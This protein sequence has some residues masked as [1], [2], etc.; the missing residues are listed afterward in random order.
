MRSVR[1]LIRPAPASPPV[2]CRCASTTGRR[3][4][5]RTP[6]TASATDTMAATTAAIPAILGKTAY[7]GGLSI[8]A[9]DARCSHQQCDGDR[10]D[11]R[12][13]EFHP[14][15]ALIATA[16]AGHCRP[17]SVL[18]ESKLAR[19]AREAAP[20]AARYFRCRRK[21]GRPRLCLTTVESDP[22]RKSIDR[23]VGSE[24]WSADYRAA[25]SFRAPRTRGMNSLPPPCPA[26]SRMCS[27]LCETPWR[28]YGI[29][30]EILIGL[31]TPCRSLSS[32]R[33]PNQF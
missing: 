33:R 1:G 7:L 18:L 27:R 6:V 22:K 10:D 24:G 5:S 32:S 25:N 30:P 11:F 14:I 28:R 13:A 26:P 4:C 23:R 16:A 12:D 3:P 20:P 15:D 9:N 2:R 31:P 8:R 29:H 17:L 21:T 19:Q